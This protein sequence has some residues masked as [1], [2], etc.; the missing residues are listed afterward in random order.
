[1]PLKPDSILGGCVR[2]NNDTTYCAE[3][4]KV[5]EEN[6][7]TREEAELARHRHTL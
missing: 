7:R 1:M 2:H 4:R 6:P 3:E 5:T